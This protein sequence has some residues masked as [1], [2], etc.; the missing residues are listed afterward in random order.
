MLAAVT[1]VPECSFG[2]VP[3]LIC[4]FHLFCALRA[5]SYYL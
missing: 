3:P 4:P 2:N 1:A 5:V